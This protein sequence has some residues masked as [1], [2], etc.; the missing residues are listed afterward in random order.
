[1]AE[2]L[3]KRV[4]K[5]RIF[6]NIPL[7]W[8]QVLHVSHAARLSP[9]SWHNYY[10]YKLTHIRP[11]ILTTNSPLELLQE[12]WQFHCYDNYCR[13][14]QLEAYGNEFTMISINGKKSE[15]GTETWGYIPKAAEPNDIISISSFNH[16]GH[17]SFNYSP[18][19][20]LASTCMVLT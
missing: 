13:A 16:T 14:A 2:D 19:A 4:H 6:S 20:S 7:S 11:H 1:V 9:G 12:N 10:I 17:A 5:M 18:V 15:F 3:K 8:P